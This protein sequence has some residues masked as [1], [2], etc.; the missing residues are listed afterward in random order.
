MYQ[1]F[2]HAIK[3]FSVKGQRSWYHWHQN[4]QAMELE[5]EISWD[6]Y[7]EIV[8]INMMESHDKVSRVWRSGQHDVF[9][10]APML[11]HHRCFGRKKSFWDQRFCHVLSWGNS[12]FPTNTRQWELG[13]D[14]ST[15]VLLGFHRSRFLESIFCQEGLQRSLET[16]ANQKL[17]R[18]NLEARAMSRV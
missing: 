18:E 9:I 14:F 11:F 4:H 2:R 10:F 8:D 5:G 13:G 3:N 16:L 6:I 1:R 17:A 12:N 15:N 7:L